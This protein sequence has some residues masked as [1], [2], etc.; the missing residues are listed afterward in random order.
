MVSLHS[1]SKHYIARS[2]DELITGLLDDG[3]VLNESLLRDAEWLMV[4]N[5]ELWANDVAR[6][7]RLF[8]SK[9]NWGNTIKLLIWIPA[10]KMKFWT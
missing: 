2:K 4:M 5:D 10:L 9:R 7:G 3:Y 1:N 8:I 6:R